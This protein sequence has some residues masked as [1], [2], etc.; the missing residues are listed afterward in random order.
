MLAK[1]SRTPEAPREAET[2]S[3]HL[4]AVT[5]VATLLADDEGDRY[6][7]SLGLD[8]EQYLPRLRMA[9]PRAGF[10]HD[11]AKAN[12]HFQ[13]AVRKDPDLPAQ[14]GWHEQLSLW[15][16]LA[17]ER[18]GTWLWQGCAPGTRHAVLAAVLG[19]HLRVEDG[20]SLGLQGRS[21]TL[22]LNVLSGHPDFAAALREGGKLLGLPDPPRL[23]DIT[24]DLVDQADFDL[25]VRRWLFDATSWW[26]A[27][28]E[29]ERRF[30][31]AL[32]A[33]LVAAD[34]AGS[35]LPR[36]GVEPVLWAK[37]ALDRTCTSDDLQQVVS[38]RLQGAPPRPFQQAVA[39]SPTRVTFVRAGCG[40]G[41]TAAAYLWARQRASERKLFFCYP[42]T[43]TASQGFADYVPPDQFEAALVHSR[44]TADL[45]D[46]L[47]NGTAD[48]EDRLEWF[49]R[50]AALVTWD[51]PI[52]VCT[53]D[54]V[55]GLV[56]NNR[57]GLFAFPAIA[58]GAFVFDEIHQYDERLFGALLRFLDAFRGVPV[59]LMTASLPKARLGALR[60]CVEGLGERLNVVEGPTDL[61]GLKRYRLE[62]ADT[63]AVWDRVTA[64]VRAGRRVLWVANVVDRAVALA[65]EALARDLPVLG[66]HSRYR[67][68]DRLERHNAVIGAFAGVTAGGALAVTTQVCEVSL[69][70]SADLLV[71]DLAPIPALIQRLGRLNRRATR[72]DSVAAAPALVLE[73]PT[74]L[75]YSAV[76]LSDA[77]RWLDLLGDASCSQSDLARAFEDTLGATPDAG[78]ATSSAWLDGGVLSARAPLREEGT[79]IPVIRAED[80][81]RLHGLPAEQKARAL[82]RLT[83]PLPLGPVARELGAWSRESGVLIAPEGRVDY[84][85]RWGGRWR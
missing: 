50:F 74:P 34:V 31:G 22:Q 4:R 44:A 16:L 64:T 5:R 83:L 79:T 63:E 24:I 46:L 66:Y 20:T 67:Y 55:L 62:R 75:P 19:H 17:D 21:G 72:A 6:L 10:A 68:G 84:D 61:E 45:E 78:F 49:T 82:I 2:L 14:A 58:N 53:V 73:P 60:S 28:D 42:T 25:S 43:G 13:R 35:A 80:W 27:A 36:R 85:E 40:S 29:A 15:L 81:R 11:L 69:D 70:I 48:G 8:P 41:K 32:K 51:A 39:S 59:L 37:G 47:S 7:T 57:G 65:Q 56:Q 30:V 76:E 26:R 52:T 77:R 71:T 12:D 54:S 23:V 3:G 38:R 18:L 1:S 33:L 9:L